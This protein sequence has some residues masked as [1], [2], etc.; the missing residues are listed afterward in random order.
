M[1]LPLPSNEDGKPQGVFVVVWGGWVVPILSGTVVFT[2][3][4]WYTVGLYV[5]FSG[6]SPCSIHVKVRMFLC[7]K[8]Q[9]MFLGG[10]LFCPLPVLFLMVSLVLPWPYRA[11]N[12]APVQAGQAALAAQQL[13]ANQDQELVIAG[14][15]AFCLVPEKFKTTRKLQAQL[16][17]VKK[18]YHEQGGMKGVAATL[19]QPEQVTWVALVGSFPRMS[20]SMQLMVIN[21]FFNERPWLKD[22]TV[23][24]MDDYWATPV[25]FMKNGGDCEEYALAKYL[26]LLDLGW[27]ENALWLVFGETTNKP[28]REWHVVVAAKVDN[29]VLYLDNTAFPKD[30]LVTEEMLLQRFAP[31]LAFAKNSVFSYYKIKKSLK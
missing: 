25:E 2:P 8:P 13:A 1:G 11:A 19:T 18:R 10:R 6:S 16:N 12:A 5:F 21:K 9:K 30:L 17:T 24:G 28:Q 20:A 3:G 7:S 15:G 31:Y 27:P 4:R 26:L 29:T 14:H 23:Y 22:A